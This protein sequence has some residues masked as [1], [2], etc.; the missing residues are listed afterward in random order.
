MLLLD[1]TGDH[2]DASFAAKVE[3]WL[4]GEDGPAGQ[5]TGEKHD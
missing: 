3:Q 5:E 4:A 1:Q 2:A